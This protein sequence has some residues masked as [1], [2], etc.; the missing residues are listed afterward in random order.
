MPIRLGSIF[1]SLARART[2]LNAAV[3]SSSGRA[4]G[5]G[6]GAAAPAEPGAGAVSGLALSNSAQSG[7]VGRS[8]YF[9]TK[10]ATPLSLSARATSHPSLPMDRIRKP[11]PGA[12]ITAAPFALPGSGRNG[13]SVACET[14]R[15]K[16]SPH[17]LYQVSFAVCPSTPPVLRG[18]AFGSAGASICVFGGS[19]AS[20]DVETASIAANRPQMAIEPLMEVGTRFLR[21]CGFESDHAT[22]SE[23]MVLR[24]Y[25][26]PPAVA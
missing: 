18:M 16:G 11:P 22:V 24:K 7:A 26:L 23:T 9:N 17:C 15:T 25:Y 14:L 21:C 4:T 12:T 2:S 13:V 3:A 8:R 20:V 6:A 5:E 1:H 10:A 19:C